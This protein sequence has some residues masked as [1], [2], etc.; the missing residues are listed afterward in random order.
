MSRKTIIQIWLFCFSLAWLFCAGI[1]FCET[2]E[3]QIK[4]EDAQ[5]F[6]RMII[7][8]TSAAPWGV[9][10]VLG[11]AAIGI[12]GT[13]A[14]IVVQIT[15]GDK[16]NK[17][18][19]KISPYLP[20]LVSADLANK[21]VGKGKID[22]KSLGE[23]L[24]I[25]AL[26]FL[27]GLLPSGLISCAYFAQN[28]ITP[29]Q[30]QTAIESAQ[31][32][33]TGIQA[34]APALFAA[35]EGICAVQ[36]NRPEWCA[37]LPEIKVDF[38]D[39]AELA[40]SLLDQALVALE[41]GKSKDAARISQ[42]LSEAVGKLAAAYLRIMTISAGSD[43]SRRYKFILVCPLW[44]ETKPGGRAFLPD[45]IFAGQVPLGMHKQM[46]GPLK[47]TTKRR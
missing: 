29:E 19:D 20:T 28:K 8:L 35:A 40:Q 17:I 6:Y 43:A 26:I 21:I 1:A 5:S 47:K 36:I 22:L 32:V 3:T 4:P 16:D 18:F 10:V 34:A 11:F 39:S 2:V 42:S 12:L 27:A 25:F 41:A 37:A 38:D 7:A 44:G 31:G 45:T 46:S 23:S 30:T 13:A 24:K 15:P 33:V 14:R 9:Y